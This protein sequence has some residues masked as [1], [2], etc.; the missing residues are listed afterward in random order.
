MKMVAGVGANR[1]VVPGVADSA[2]K[3]ASV[4]APASSTAFQ[5]ILEQTRKEEKEVIFSAHARS[6]LEQRK[7]KF[8]QEDL[9]KI[10]EAMDKAAAKGA[11][12]PLLLYNN[13]ALLASVPNR[14]IITAVDGAVEKEQIYTHIDSAV[15]FK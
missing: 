6:R 11:R 5:Q 8:G 2:A 15:I 1:P 7:I 13:I 12:S 3:A 9:Q 10:T 4:K 14:T